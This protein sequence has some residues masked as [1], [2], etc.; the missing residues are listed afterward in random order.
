MAVAGDGIIQMIEVGD[1]V[2]DKWSLG[3]R[4]RRGLNVYIVYDM[5]QSIVLTCDIICLLRS[6][7]QLD[8]TYSHMLEPFNAP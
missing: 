5:E 8:S 1:I 2:R 4:V 3:E 6:N 7:G